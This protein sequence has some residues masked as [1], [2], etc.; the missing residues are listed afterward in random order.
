MTPIHASAAK[1]FSA[2]AEAY[3]RGRPEYPEAL[4]PWLQDSL[5]LGPGR[6]AVDLG[7]GTGKFTRLLAA[8][9]AALVAVEPVAAMRN[10]LALGLPGVRVVEGTAQAMPL[11]DAT[12][13]AVL[14]AQAFHWFATREALSEIHRVVAPGGSLGL[15]WNMR[16][17][18]V[19]WVAALSDLMAP[20]EGDT[21]R[22]HGGAW[23]KAFTGELFGMP[24][25]VSFTHVHE[26]SPRAVI[27]DR[28]LSVSFIASLPDLERGRVEDRLL[29]LVA[30]HPELRGRDSVRFPYRTH[31]FRCARL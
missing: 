28:V 19:D 21:P 22:F 17:E 6:T 23:R 27:V 1:G 29:D 9:G 4:L 18:T 20:Y 16:D 14:C 13:H 31:A 25:E 15:V 7:A 11:D 24:E 30:T 26:G 12:A 10:Q 3:A 2:A 5:G 8:T